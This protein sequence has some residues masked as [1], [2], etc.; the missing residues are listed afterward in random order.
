MT[1][2]RRAQLEAE[3][4]RTLLADQEKIAEGRLVDGVRQIEAALSRPVN[5]VKVEA[6]TVPVLKARARPK[7]GFS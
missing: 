6:Q 2:E 3:R 7:K 4:Q 5:T 1:E